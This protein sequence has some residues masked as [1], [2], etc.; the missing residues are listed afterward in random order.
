MQQLG[1]CLHSFSCSL[2]SALL[3]ISIVVCIEWRSLVCTAD[4]DSS[5]VEGH[6]YCEHP[7]DRDGQSV[8]IQRQADYREELRRINNSLRRKPATGQ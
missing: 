3:V 2:F 1:L 6:G 5:E 7:S 4:V 8:D